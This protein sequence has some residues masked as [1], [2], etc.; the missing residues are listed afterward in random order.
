VKPVDDRAA[1]YLD[2]FKEERYL[3]L[4]TFLQVETPE[5]IVA[6]CRLVAKYDNVTHLEFVRRLLSE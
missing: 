1:E 4:T 6:F 3:E 5:T 2:M